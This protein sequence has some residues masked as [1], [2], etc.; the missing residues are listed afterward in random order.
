MPKQLLSLFE[1]EAV[2][3]AATLYRS[4]TYLYVHSFNFHAIEIKLRNFHIDV[5]VY[6]YYTNFAW[7][8]HFDKHLDTA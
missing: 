2:N 5:R 8:A 7:F 1:P 6:C 4:F 3:T